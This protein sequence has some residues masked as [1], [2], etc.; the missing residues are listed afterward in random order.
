M[1]RSFL[2][3]VFAAAAKK[4]FAQHAEYVE[5]EG[6]GCPN[7]KTYHECIDGIRN[8]AFPSDAV[9]AAAAKKGM[10]GTLST[11]QDQAGTN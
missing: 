4:G 8:G 11:H 1:C 3:L 10:Q 2:F 9:F 7:R 6:I 5:S